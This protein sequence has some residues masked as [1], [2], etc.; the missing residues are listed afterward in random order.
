MKKFLRY[1]LAFVFIFNIGFSA[2][3][4]VFAGNTS[5]HVHFNVKLANT[6]VVTVTYLNVDSE[7]LSGNGGLYSTT[8]S[9]NYVSNDISAV[10]VND[11]PVAYRLGT[12]GKG[13][14]INL[15][16]GYPEP[17][18]TITKTAD[19]SSALR[20]DI[21][22]YTITVTN[23]DKNT[24][25]EGVEVVD[26]M[27]DINQLADIA[28]KGYVV[29][30]EVYTVPNDQAA[31]VMKN[32]A[33]A[34]IW[35]VTKSAS[36][37]VTIF[38]PNPALSIVKSGTFVDTNGD[39][40]AQAGE[41]INYTFAVKNEGN[42]ALAN[43]VVTDPKVNVSG[44]PTT[45]DIGET[46]NTTFTASYTITGAD[47]IA[48]SVYNLASADSDESDPA[49]D[50]VT[51]TLP[52]EGV[53][54]NPALSIVKSG[55]FV[56][57]NGDSY[58]QAGEKINYTFTVENEG[59]VALTNVVVTDPKVNVS[60]GPTTL[61]IG[62]TD[63][64]TFT[65][66][67]TITGADIIAGSV[68][69]LATADS[70]ESDSATDDVTV[71]LPKE[72]VTPNPALSIVKSGTFDDTNGDS[73]AQAGEK[74]NYTFTVE[75]E[76]N[77]ALTNVV[78]TDPNVNVSGGPTTLEIGETDNTTF[79][80]SYTITGA[81]IIAGSVYNLATVD[82]DES[83]PATDDVTVTLP[84]EEVTPSPAFNITK[85]SD[86]NSAHRG[87]KI[88]YTII[89]TN[90]GNVEL[91]N[92]SVT[93][94]LIG[95]VGTI[96]NLAVKSFAQ[97]TKTYN[98]PSNQDYGTMRNTAEA[99]WNQTTKSAFKDVNIIKHSSGGGTTTI[100]DEEDPQGPALI[101]GLKVTKDVDKTVVKAG[102]TLKYTITV[103]N[104][105]N[106]EL[107]N[108]SVT[109][110][111]IGLSENIATLAAGETKTFVKDYVVPAGTA[112]GTLKNTATA[113][114]VYNNDP[115]TASGSAVTNV[116]ADEQPLV[117]IPEEEAPKGGLPQ[118][119]GIPLT[120][121]FAIGSGLA[122]LG[123]LLRRKQ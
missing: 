80:A 3:N 114:A 14:T 109:D 81:D 6:D 78:V 53:T 50:D 105:G 1:L 71:T 57:T 17:D 117:D 65:A 113:S 49:T 20:G 16:V 45:L 4:L 41:K 32:T 23:N 9:G 100:V 24:D 83:D 28:K 93:D 2:T 15:W 31:G 119:G 106:V 48:G 40:Y 97:F 64:T 59:N 29:I 92:I 115:V 91:A 85:D 88:T 19:K 112:V 67:Y 44:G 8:D 107:T 87:D 86:V 116:K 61:D 90:T 35:G 10:K 39:S 55:T 13:G 18:F 104:T 63:N 25:L 38:V 30:T 37:N 123:F 69:N 94:T 68:Y 66:S 82:S 102:D 101:P 5:I 36:A 62:E 122:A 79:T 47:I 84:K 77:V 60:G 58:A 110:S 33:T 52:K 51:V 99:T 111:L 56:D 120:D 26:S 27:L 98:V 46:D 21:V 108:V 95:F 34:S 96:E 89:V 12:E 118:T 103:K 43:V 74:I 72:G 70:D 76:G 73:Y 11:V 7:P 75:N 121:L 22:T 42:V 54:P